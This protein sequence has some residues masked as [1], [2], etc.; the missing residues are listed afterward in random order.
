MIENPDWPIRPNGLGRTVGLVFHTPKYWNCR[1]HDFDMGWLWVSPPLDE[2]T[3]ERR[4]EEML[5]HS[6]CRWPYRHRSYKGYMY[7]IGPKRRYQLNYMGPLG[8]G[9]KPRA[10]FKVGR[11]NDYVR[12]FDNGPKTS[13]PEFDDEDR[14]II[15][16][17]SRHTADEAKQIKREMDEYRDRREA[18]DG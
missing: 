12:W 7:W 6:G 4:Y 13:S 16:A 9:Q 5:A 11:H 17:I 8:L 14:E 18:S 15:S 3:K 10:W 1:K 2:H